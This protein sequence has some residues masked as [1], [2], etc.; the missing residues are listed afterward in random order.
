M[1]EVMCDIVNLDRRLCE[2]G[3]S[4]IRLCSARADSKECTQQ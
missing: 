3:E 1:L 2:N 4:I